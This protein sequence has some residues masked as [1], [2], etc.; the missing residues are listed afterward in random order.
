MGIPP[1]GD[2]GL[3]T[4]LKGMTMENHSGTYGIGGDC[5]HGLESRVPETTGEVGLSHAILT[6]IK[7]LSG[8]L[9]PQ[10]ISESFRTLNCHGL[11]R[12]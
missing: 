5:S 10:D 3:C 7:R 12:G 11:E 6:S 1:F 4:G 2:G 9:T 8:G